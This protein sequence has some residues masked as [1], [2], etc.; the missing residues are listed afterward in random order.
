M[1]VLPWRKAQD[2]RITCITADWQLGPLR[3]QAT[4][5]VNPDNSQDPIYH[6]ALEGEWQKAVARQEPYGRSTLGKSQAEV[7][8]IHC[9][10]AS[11][12]ETI[13]RLIYRAVETCCYWSSIRLE[14]TRRSGP[15]TS[16]AETTN[17]PIST[18]GSR[19]PP[20]IESRQSQCE[21]MAPW[22]LRVSSRWG[23]PLSPVRCATGRTFGR[24]E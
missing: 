9:S 18:A 10:F 3:G 6:L 22:T 13:A 8:F 12:V 4:N 21:K 17:S 7:G 23:C 2:L 19:S 20:S 11:Q 5:V 1:S 24:R 15:K 16:T 14:S